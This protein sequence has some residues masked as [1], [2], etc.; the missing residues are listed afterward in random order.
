M[1]CKF[2][3]GDIIRWGN[4][5]IFVIGKII[6][7]GEDRFFFDKLSTNAYRYL[8]NFIFYTNQ[9]NCKLILKCPEYLHE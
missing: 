7:L 9:N 4:D 1:Q 5:Y 2:K 3:V 6:K 8:P